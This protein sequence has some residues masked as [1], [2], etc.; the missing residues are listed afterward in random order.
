MSES[1]IDEPVPPPPAVFA[2]I[3]VA[4]VGA[5]TALIVELATAGGAPFGIQAGF[6]AAIVVGLVGIVALWYG[7]ERRQSFIS[8][9][10]SEALDIS[11]FES[12]K[13]CRPDTSHRLTEIEAR[14]YQTGADADARW[15]A[16]LRRE[17]AQGPQSS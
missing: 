12:E 2:G 7:F 8:A 6:A 5:I 13:L 10:R 14:L 3:A 17:R 11:S 16:D 9:R 1:T 15:V 4:S